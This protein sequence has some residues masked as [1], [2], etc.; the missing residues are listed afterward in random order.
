MEPRNNGSSASHHHGSLEPYVNDVLNEF[1]KRIDISPNSRVR[2]I[3]S[4][5]IDDNL[6]RLMVS[7]VGEYPITIP[8]SSEE[9]F[10]SAPLT[11][12]ILLNKKREL[13]SYKMFDPESDVINALARELVY[14]IKKGEIEFINSDE[15]L[16]DIS[17]FKKN[18][19]FFVHRDGRGKLHL[20]QAYYS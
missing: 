19:P 11:A 2:V 17:Q 4:A 6:K 9:I 5:Q 15:K 8:E 10:V 1:K 14:K 3:E 12:E 18:K 16:S 13:V 20:K 7:Y